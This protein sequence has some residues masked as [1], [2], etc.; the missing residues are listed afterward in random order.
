MAMERVHTSPVRSSGRARDVMGRKLT[1]QKPALKMKEGMAIRIHL[2]MAG[3]IRELALFSLGMDSQLRGRDLVRLRVEDVA[4]AGTVKN[5][6]A[7]V[8]KKTGR[9]VQFEI[10]NQAWAAVGDLIEK[11]GL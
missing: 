2:K 3:K 4:V 8:Q 6:A 10:T 7:I 1:G 11:H 9:P 5:R